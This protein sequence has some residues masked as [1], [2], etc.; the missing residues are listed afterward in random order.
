MV[1]HSDKFTHDVR[2]L[3]SMMRDEPV[4]E[5]RDQ[6]DVDE[7]P[8]DVWVDEAQEESW[9]NVA[10]APIDADPLDNFV[11]TP[12][13]GDDEVQDDKGNG[14]QMPKGLPE[15]KPPSVRR[16]VDT[17]SRTGHMPAGAPIALWEGATTLLM[18][19]RAVARI[20]LSLFWCWTTASCGMHLTRTL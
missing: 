13:G 4:E 11:C 9:A 10:D 20:A 15:P 12:C 1:Y 3:I 7:I 6:P 19:R 5:E 14:F 2:P 17:T 18:L 16:N 8:D